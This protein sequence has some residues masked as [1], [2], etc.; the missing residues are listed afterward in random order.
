MIKNYFDP[1]DGTT[2]EGEV[3]GEAAPETPAEP[4]EPAPQE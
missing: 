1:E 2:S 3:P 4:T